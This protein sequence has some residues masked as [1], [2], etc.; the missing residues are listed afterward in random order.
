MKTS[1]YYLLICFYAAL[2]AA[3]YYHTF[4]ILELKYWKV[5]DYNREISKREKDFGSI[6]YDFYNL[7]DDELIAL[8]KEEEKLY[9]IHLY[10][11]R[12]LFLLAIALS[13]LFLIRNYPKYKGQSPHLIKLFQ[14]LF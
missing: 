13:T 12:P 11:I 7:S 3:T 1:V 4:E 9:K 10:L 2:I 5:Y 8:G 6:K 14:G